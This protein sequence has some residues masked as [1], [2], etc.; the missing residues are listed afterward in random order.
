[1]RTRWRTLLGAVVAALLTATTLVACSADEAD[2]FV[3]REGRQLVVDGSPFR[4]VGVNLYDAAASDRYSCRPASRIPADDLEEQFRWL[5]EDAGVTVVRFWA[6]QTYTDSGRDFSAVDRVVEAARRAGVR[7]LPVLE[8]GPGDCS[9][10]EP[11][12]SLA[13]ADGG[14]YYSEGYRRP[15]GDARSSLRDYARA[16]ATH[17]RDEPTILGWM[18]VNEAETSERDSRGR[19]VLVSFAG[20]LSAV[21]HAADPNHLVTLG[22]QGN[23]APGGSGADFR[24]V[25]NQQGLDFV[26]VHD[27]ARY[28]SDTEALPGADGTT[29]PDPG[30]AECTSTSAPVACSFAIA[31]EI[32]KPLVVGEA[33]ITATD[34]AGRQRRADL[35]QAKVS[36]ALTAGAAGYLL[37]HYSS[38][39][40]DGYD[41]VRSTGDPAF[42]VL[43]RAAAGL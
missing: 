39:G 33:G 27:W 38:T 15:Y 20:D 35:L 22:T 12:T 29:L 4:F 34:A 3:T 6:Y 2:G 7:L 26:E 41:L 23:G 42:G 8:D 40:T 11:G 43:H 32:G 5:R 14:R 25:Y 21:V 28:G 31:R 37:W 19:S 10:G 24:E 30:S 13:Q 36:A 16:I 1:M 18:L 17:Y 9:T